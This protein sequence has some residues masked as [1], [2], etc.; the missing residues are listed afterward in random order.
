MD[1]GD[2]TPSDAE[3]MFRLTHGDQRAFAP[4]QHRHERVV[5]MVALAACRA[6]ADAEDVVALVFLDLWRKRDSVPLV[7]GSVRPWLI[8]TAMFHARNQTRGMRRYQRL[9]Q[10]LPASENEPDHADDVGDALDAQYAVATMR[11]AFAQLRR[12]DSDVLVL[13]VVEGLSMEDAA[14]TLGI[15]S[16]TV[17]SRLSRAKQR[18][19]GLMTGGEPD[20]QVATP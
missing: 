1:E 8:T 7:D 5:Y 4:I 16:G 2:P 10:K 14:V 15:P 6:H 20:G 11:V 17:K 13:C 9:L 19:R 12:S 3:L 18:L